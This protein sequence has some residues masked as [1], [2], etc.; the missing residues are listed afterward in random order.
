MN[1]LAQKGL[2]QGDAETSAQ[3]VELLK[4]NPDFLRGFLSAAPEVQDAGM[5]QA[6][7]MGHGMGMGQG[8]G[9]M[10]VGVGG[11]EMDMQFVG[12]S[13]TTFHEGIGENGHMGGVELGDLGIGSGL[14]YENLLADGMTFIEPALELHPVPTSLETSMETS[15]ET[16][17]TPAPIPRLETKSEVESHPTDSQPISPAVVPPP[18]IPAPAFIP[19]PIVAT[20]NRAPIERIQ[21]FGFPPKMG[22]R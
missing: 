10:G 9:A 12:S 3:L 17:S 11:G 16:A 5:G 18:P 7:A 2:D 20:Q 14:Q 21:A 6:S 13:S 8:I 4:S 22:Q 15:L 19:I 1:L